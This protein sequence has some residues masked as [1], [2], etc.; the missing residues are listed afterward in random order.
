MFQAFSHHI[1]HRLK[2]VFYPRVD[3]K[4]RVTFLSRDT[5]YRKVLNERQLLSA[6][7]GNPN[8]VVSRVSL[9]NAKK[10]SYEC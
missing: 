5:M 10:C 2:I 1:L 9:P 3:S 4:L 8:Y 6:L 7:N